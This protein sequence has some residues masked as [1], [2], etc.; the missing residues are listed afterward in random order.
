MY[1]TLSI[2]FLT[3]SMAQAQTTLLCEDNFDNAS[4]VGCA[5]NANALTSFSRQSGQLSY[6]QQGLYPGSFSFGSSNSFDAYDTL[7]LEMDFIF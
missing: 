2:L 4:V 5:L 6:F 3:A 7:K 1:K